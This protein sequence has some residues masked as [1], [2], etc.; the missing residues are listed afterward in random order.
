MLPRTMAANNGYLYPLC[1]GEEAYLYP[2]C[3]GEEADGTESTRRSGSL[4]L[5]L[6][7]H[8]ANISGDNTRV[9]GVGNLICDDFGYSFCRPTSASQ[10]T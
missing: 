4:S 9:V 5:I 6:L 2:L 7:H 8:S 3:V 1:V 10:R